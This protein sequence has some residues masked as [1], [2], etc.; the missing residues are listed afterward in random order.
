MSLPVLEKKTGIDPAQVFLLSNLISYQDGSVVSRTLINEKSG[1]VTLFS[2]DATQGLSEHTSPY[3]ALAQILEG[4]VE[5]AISGN[6]M[7]VRS[8]ELV[9]LPAGQPHKLLAVTRFKMLLTMIRSEMT[10]HRVKSISGWNT[11]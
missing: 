8:G 1:T 4:E 9:L 5:I 3:N 10:H 6:P 11:E 7:K 2:F